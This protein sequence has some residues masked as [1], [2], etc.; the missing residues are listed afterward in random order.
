MASLIFVRTKVIDRKSALRVRSSSGQNIQWKLQLFLL[1]TLPE[2]QA[3]C[4][5]TD[6]A[7]VFN[8][9]YII[10]RMQFCQINSSRIQNKLLPHKVLLPE[11]LNLI[12][13]SAFTV[14][15]KYRD[16]TSLV[17]QWLRIRLSM[18]GTQVQSLIREDPTCHGATEPVPNYQAHILHLLKPCVP[19]AH[20][21]QQEKS[22]QWE[23]HVPQWRVAP[24]HC[25]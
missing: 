12:R 24:T 3:T 16:R 8:C 4:I 17:V 9:S 5:S 1:F 15:K 21:P 14:F 2:S 20:A 23:A 18:Q 10:T 22:L 7:S 11:M 6:N 13:C 25:N 19:R